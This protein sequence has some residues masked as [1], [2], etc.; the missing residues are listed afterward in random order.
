LALSRSRMRPK[1]AI[2]HSSLCVALRHTTGLG[3]KQ[4]G[5]PP[6]RMSF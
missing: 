3:Q 4:R 6:H 2:V 5:P 1:I